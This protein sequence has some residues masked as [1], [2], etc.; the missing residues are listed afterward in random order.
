MCCFSEKHKARINHTFVVVENV[1][2]VLNAPVINR[3]ACSFLTQSLLNFKLG[4]A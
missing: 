3:S 2:L 1:D 4:L